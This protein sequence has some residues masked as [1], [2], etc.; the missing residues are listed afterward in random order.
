MRLDIAIREQSTK[1]CCCIYMDGCSEHI[2]RFSR[3]Q[4][5]RRR[6]EV[7]RRLLAI[8]KE[9]LKKNKRGRWDS[10]SEDEGAS[11]TNGKGKWSYKRAKIVEETFNS[12]EQGNGV[13]L[14]KYQVVSTYSAFLESRCDE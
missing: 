12:T 2:Q 4:L 5:E 13:L 8:E 14:G 10:D 9:E 3:D 6:I 7:K 1:N 11:T